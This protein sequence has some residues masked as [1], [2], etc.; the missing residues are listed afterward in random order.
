MVALQR[1]AQK[2]EY[3][4]EI[5]LVATDKPDAEGIKKAKKYNLKCEVID[6]KKNEFEDILHQVIAEA[7]ADYICL[8]G[9]MRILSAEFVN[10]WERKIIN[11][12]PSLLPKFPGLNTHKRA[13]EAKEKIH[14]CTVH[15][16]TAELDAG[17]KILHKTIDIEKEKCAKK[18]A[19]KVL[20]E[21]H[22]LYPKAL[23]KVIS[24]EP[25]IPPII[26]ILTQCGLWYHENQRHHAE[27]WNQNLSK[28]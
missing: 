17:D 20:R 7:K 2:N 4:F 25:K 14:G 28:C 18:V 13:L 16:V 12:H 6:G 5:V 23:K 22:Q 21:E 24:E 27:P 1:A 15:Y 26:K 10:K 9:F 11:I 19:K 3:P 8:A